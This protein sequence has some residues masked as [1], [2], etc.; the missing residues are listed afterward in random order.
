MLE[1]NYNKKEEFTIV[2]TDFIL[3]RQNRKENSEW[4]EIKSLAENA[5]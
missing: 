3:I 4:M 5:R 1:E 2:L